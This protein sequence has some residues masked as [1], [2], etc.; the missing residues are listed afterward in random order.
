M[1]LLRLILLLHLLCRL[2]RVHRRVRAALVAGVLVPY[3]AKA[4]CALCLV[5]SRCGYRG[6]GVATG[7]AGGR[8]HRQLW[9][10][11]HRCRRLS[12]AWTSRSAPT[13][14]GELP[15][16]AQAAPS[17]AQHRRVSQHVP[18]PR[19]AQHMVQSGAPV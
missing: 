4:P 14:L 17:A 6:N 2:A 19:Q 9:T 3:A 18:V 8:A 13:S 15:F 11:L 1:P 5:R 10:C 7:A 12:W 16:E